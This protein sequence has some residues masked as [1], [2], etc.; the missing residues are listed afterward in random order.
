MYLMGTADEA[1]PAADQPAS[2]VARTWR[3]NASAAIHPDDERS[4]APLAEGPQA[5]INSGPIR[6]HGILT[7]HAIAILLS[8]GRCRRQRR[9]NMI[10]NLLI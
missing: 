4:V 3:S 6:I 1:V 7:G 2:I 9:G 8:A 10:F 5:N